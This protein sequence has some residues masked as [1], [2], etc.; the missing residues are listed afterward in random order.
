MARNYIQPGEVMDYIA[1]G[2]ISAG[3]VVVVGDRIGVALTDM[4]S[5]QMGALQMSGVF[6]LPALASDDI[7]PG[8]QLYWDAGNTRLTLT[9][10]THKKAGYAFAAAGVGVAT[11]RVKLNG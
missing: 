3:A 7:V 6:E 5:G 1:G 4:V 10:S 2:T 11:C 9:A 8:A